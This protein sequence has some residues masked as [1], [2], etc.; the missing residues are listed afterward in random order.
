MIFA[1]F[2]KYIDFF[3]TIYS[4]HAFSILQFLPD[5]PSHHPS[6]SIPFLCQQKGETHTSPQRQKPKMLSKRPVSQKKKLIFIVFK[7]YV[8]F[9]WIFFIVEASKCSLYILWMSFIDISFLLH[10]LV[11]YCLLN[12]SFHVETLDFGPV[13]NL[14]SVSKSIDLVRVWL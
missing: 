6:N 9:C 4:D 8:V 3:H 1:L 10:I 12:N 7:R 11:D 5:P 14:D 13:K 2:L